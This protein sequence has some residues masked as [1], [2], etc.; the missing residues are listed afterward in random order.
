MRN[1]VVEA[2][3]L[4]LLSVLPM[5]RPMFAAGVTIKVMVAILA[6]DWR[7]AIAGGG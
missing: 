6:G 3:P 1:C 2:I 5:T 4:M 7:L